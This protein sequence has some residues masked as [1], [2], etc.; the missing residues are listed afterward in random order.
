MLEAW[1]ENTHNSEDKGR[2]SLR[3]NQAAWVVEASY[4]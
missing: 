3:S 1:E 4:T 2:L